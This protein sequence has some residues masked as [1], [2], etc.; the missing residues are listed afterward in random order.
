VDAKSV[1]LLAAEATTLALPGAGEAI[2]ID[3]AHAAR[4]ER[5]AARAHRN[6]HKAA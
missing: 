1:E 2:D 6:A 3:D 4:R 5:A